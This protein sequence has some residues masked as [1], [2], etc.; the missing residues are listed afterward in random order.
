M[1]REHASNLFLTV[2]RGV[3]PRGTITL[4]D[5]GDASQ[6]PW[7]FVMH[8]DSYMSNGSVVRA[9]LQSLAEAAHP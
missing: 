4:T 5:V 9:F 1:E 3:S 8:L 6:E 2:A 7:D